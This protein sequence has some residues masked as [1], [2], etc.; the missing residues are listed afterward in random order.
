VHGLIAE[1]ERMHTHPRIK[2]GSLEEG[3]QTSLR[4]AMHAWAVAAA[5]CADSLL[6]S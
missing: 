2:Q 5:A 1:M 6:V 4:A 3:E